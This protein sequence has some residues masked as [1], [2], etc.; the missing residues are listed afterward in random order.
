MLSLNENSIEDCM[1]M[2][3]ELFSLNFTLFSAVGL[4]FTA[5]YAKTVNELYKFSIMKILP[6]E[7]SKRWYKIG[8]NVMIAVFLMLSSVYLI[9]A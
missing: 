6:T 2:Q 7:V 5:Q 3:K 9:L 4:L 8:L 1:F